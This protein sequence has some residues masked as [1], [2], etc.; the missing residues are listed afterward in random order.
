MRLFIS[1]LSF[2]LRQTFITIDPLGIAFAASPKFYNVVFSFLFLQDIF[3]FS[4]DLFFDQLVCSGLCC[5]AHIFV[6]FPV[7]LLESCLVSHCV[8]AG[9]VVSVSY[10]C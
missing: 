6:N 9:G 1:G 8:V 2:S 7:F 4:F 10:T 3:D 5:L